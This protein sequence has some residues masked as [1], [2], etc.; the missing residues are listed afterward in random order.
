MLIRNIATRC[1]VLLLLP[2][3][4]ITGC[5][6]QEYALPTPADGL[7]NDVIKRTL[8]PNMVGQ[9][10]EFAYAMGILPD[11]GKLTSATVEA[12][13]PGAAGT[14]LENNTYYTNGSGVDVPINIGAPS[15]TNG[16]NTT[17]TFGKDTATSTLRYFYVIPEEARGKTVS[18]TF[19]AKSSN[20]QTVTY[21]M[22]PYTI[23]KMDMVRNLTVSNNANAYISIE[24]MAV[25]NS[26]AAA[27]NAG[28]IDLV[29]LF[30][31]IT[32]SAFNHALVAPAADPVYLPGVTLPNGVNR[33]T[34]MRKEF[35]LQDNNLARTQFGIYIDDR[36]L[37]EINL[38]ESPMYAINMRAEAG[39]WVETD[40]GKYRAFV[41]LNSVNAAGTAVISIKR[42]AL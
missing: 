26:A 38:S 18:F 21:K 11:K 7:Q 29:Y 16:T 1:A 28:K 33:K 2:A 5:K 19:S 35:G 17:V 20:G 31:N 22:G 3:L 15:V 42:I 10:I 36:D 13:I 37:L 24:D 27:A 34:R 30:R 14:Y 41:Y 12:T 9:Q 40:G 32:T 6:K 23:S 25:Y 39:I 8:G 4:M